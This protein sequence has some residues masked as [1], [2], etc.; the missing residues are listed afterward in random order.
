MKGGQQVIFECLELTYGLCIIVW[1]SY[2]CSGSCQGVW[3][4]RSNC[5]NVTESQIS[6]HP[7]M[8]PY[9]RSFR[10][11]VTIYKCRLGSKPVSAGARL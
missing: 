11:S 4:S 3:P 2:Q 10:G 9:C 6:T 8:S 7:H 1:K 5:C